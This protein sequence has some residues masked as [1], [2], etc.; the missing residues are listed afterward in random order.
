[1]KFVDFGD[2]VEVTY[3]NGDQELLSKEDALALGY[4]ERQEIEI[5]YKGEVYNATQFG[6]K[7]KISINAVCRYYKKGY[8]TGEEIIDAYNKQKDS[9]KEIQILYNNNTYNSNQFSKLSGISSTTIQACYKKGITSGEEI[10]AEHGTKIR[11]IEYKNQYLTQEQLSNLTKIPARIISQYYEQGIR[12]GEKM[13]QLWCETKHKKN[14]QV[15]KI[16]YMG[17]YYTVRQLSKL[18]NI[19]ETNIR[20]YYYKRGLTTG[21]QMKACHKAQLKIQHGGRV[22]TAAEFGREFNVSNKTVILLYNKGLRTGE[23]ILQRIAEKQQ[24]IKTVTYNGQIYTLSNFCK[25][26]NVSYKTFSKYYNETGLRTGE[27]LLDHYYNNRYK[28]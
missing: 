22:Y 11:N 26:T 17:Q 3:D 1:M 27:E 10:I 14:M 28:H 6:R 24:S 18:I 8:C 9:K 21:E 20:T 25:Q 5:T 16:S 13:E 19:P 23:A 7:V 2:L 4:K 12:S 15:L